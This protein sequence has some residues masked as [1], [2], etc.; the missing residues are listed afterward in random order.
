M[1]DN[2]ER[3]FRFWGLVLP[4]AIVLLATLAG[5]ATRRGGMHPMDPGSTLS[6]EIEIIIDNRNFN[7][8]TVYTA[9]AGASRRLGIVP[10]KGQAT[11]RVRWFLPTIQLRVKFLAGADFFTESLPVSPGEILELIIPIRQQD[12]AGPFGSRFK[13]QTRSVACP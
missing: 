9:R 2:A 12:L 7:Q 1:A 6:D 10:G 5:C 3:R 13:Y 11:F 4:I 8:V